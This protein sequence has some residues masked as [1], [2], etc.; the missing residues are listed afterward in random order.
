MDFKRAFDTVNCEM[1]FYELV[2][3]GRPID[4]SVIKTSMR[5]RRTKMKI[6][7]DGLLSEIFTDE[8]GVNQGGPNSPDM[9]VD[10]LSDLRDLMKNVELL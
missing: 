8:A 5:C 1:M 6:C 4:G 10:F 2:K 9:F 7:L 3:R